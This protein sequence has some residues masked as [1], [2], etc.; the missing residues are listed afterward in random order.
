MKL[1]IDPNIIGQKVYFDDNT[2]HDS[3]YNIYYG[4]PGGRALHLPAPRG[5]GAAARRAARARQAAAAGAGRVRQH[6]QVA[7]RCWTRDT[8]FECRYRQVIEVSVSNSVRD[9]LRVR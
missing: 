3:S 8:A 6:V 7:A 2:I 5:A 4:R 9:A 1:E